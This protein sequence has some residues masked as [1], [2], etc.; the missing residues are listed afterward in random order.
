MLCNIK[1][2]FMSAKAKRLLKK[3]VSYSGIFFFIL[4][5]F[6]LWWQLREYSLSDI[7]HA[8][9]NIPFVNLLAACIACLAGYI[10]LSLY[11]YLAL[12]YIGARVS[13]WK[14]MLAGMLGF[15]ISNNAGNAVVSGGA[16]RYRLY[17]RWRINGGDIV[18][19]IT[20]SGLT[21][22]MGCSLIVIIGYMLVPSRILEQSLG[23]SV[24]I[25][26]LFIICMAT[27][28]AYF[29]TTIFFSKKSIKIGKIKFHIPTTKTAFY[30]M[31]LGAMDSILAGLVL[32]FCLLPF[33][34]IPFGTYIGLFVIAQATGV[35]SQVPGGIGVFES[36][37]LLALPD[38]VDKADIFGALLAYRIIYYVLPLIGVGGLFFIYEN[39]LRTRM[40]RWLA[41]AKEKIPHIPH[42]VKNT[43]HRKK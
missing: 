28:L 20:F 30:Q 16:I 40:K 11:D 39:W 7:F 36:I 41:E 21:F 24:G 34:H 5:A 25:N 29:A 32:Y 23:A 6:M 4:A 27:V 38:G 9:V 42:T 18:K 1:G 26:T 12:R 13:W 3:L 37:F 31:V 15:A 22:F 33:V 2:I 10:C 43:K 14:W 19:M 8:L 17:T 35:F